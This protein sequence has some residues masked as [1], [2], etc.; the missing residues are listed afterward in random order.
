MTLYG[1]AAKLMRIIFHPIH[2]NIMTYGKGGK[3]IARGI[4]M[5]FFSIVT[6]QVNTIITQ[7]DRLLPEVPIR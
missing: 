6:H 7:V 5:F 3:E 4:K 1:H 2:V